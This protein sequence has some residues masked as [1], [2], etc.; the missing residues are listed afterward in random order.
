MFVRRFE[1][2][3]LSHPSHQG[4]II[5]ITVFNPQ[6]SFELFLFYSQESWSKDKTLDSPL[7]G[8]PG[9][10][11]SCLLTLKL[12]AL[13]FMQCY[14]HIHSIRECMLLNATTHFSETRTLQ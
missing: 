7:G 10:T 9:F 13:C 14:P 5:P 2:L 11:E 4:H 12:W 1:T 6:Q 8:E 3:A